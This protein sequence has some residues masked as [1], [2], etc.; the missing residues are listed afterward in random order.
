MALGLTSCIKAHCT[1]VFYFRK[2]ALK[3]ANEKKNVLDSHPTMTSAVQVAVEIKAVIQQLPLH[4]MIRKHTLTIKARL[5]LFY[6]LQ[7]R[8]LY[9]LQT[10]IKK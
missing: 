8:R 9:F 2:G 10:E 4:M 5:F 6:G 1:V 3:I 7:I